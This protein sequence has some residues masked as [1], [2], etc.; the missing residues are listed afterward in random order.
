MGVESH[1]DQTDL[2][3]WGVASGR[4]HRCLYGMKYESTSAQGKS[5]IN[6]S[7]DGGWRGKGLW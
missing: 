5:S 4:A 6:I 2:V 3:I 7:P 1:V